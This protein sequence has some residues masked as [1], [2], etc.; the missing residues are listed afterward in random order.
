M[1][2]GSLSS[3]LGNFIVHFRCF[4]EG[5]QIL[6]LPLMIN[7]FSTSKIFRMAKNCLYQ[8]LHGLH[9]AYAVWRFLRTGKSVNISNNDPL[10]SHFSQSQLIQQCLCIVLQREGNCGFVAYATLSREQS[11]RDIELFFIFSCQ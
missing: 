5:P 3:T 1:I 9:Q 4:H 2:Q 6:Y 7:Q 10:R 8:V 11:K